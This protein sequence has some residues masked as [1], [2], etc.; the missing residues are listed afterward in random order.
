MVGLGHVRQK[1]I[2]ERKAF[3]EILDILIVTEEIAT[4]SDK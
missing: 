3:H 2:L 4:Y 1:N